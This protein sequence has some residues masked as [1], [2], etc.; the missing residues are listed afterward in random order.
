MIWLLSQHVCFMLTVKP[1]ILATLNFDIWGNSVILDPV[2][3]AFFASCY[4][5]T[6][7]YSIFTNLPGSRNSR[8][9]GQAKKTGLQYSGSFLCADMLIKLKFCVIFDGPWKPVNAVLEK[10]FWNWFSKHSG[11]FGKDLATTIAES[12]SWQMWCY[13]WRRFFSV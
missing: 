9:K 4:T 2:I 7:L 11:Y 3:S 5:E 10:S 13:I 8:N 1:L 12:C 6:L